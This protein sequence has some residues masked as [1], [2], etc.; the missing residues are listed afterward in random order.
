MMARLRING[1]AL[2]HRGLLMDEARTPGLRG[3][4]IDN[5]VRGRKRRENRP[6]TR[7]LVVV[8]GVSVAEVEHRGPGRRRG[9]GPGIVAPFAPVLGHLQLDRD[10]TD[11]QGGHF[12]P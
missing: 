11:A 5:A 3:A 7:F 1:A 2:S 6:R 10:M 9:G 12:G 4:Y 8:A